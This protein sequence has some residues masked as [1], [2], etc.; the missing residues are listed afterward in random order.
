MKLLKSTW[1]DNL[2]DSFF[3]VSQPLN[4]SLHEDCLM[5]AAMNLTQLT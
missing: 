3:S 5:F 2:F 1:W 4:L